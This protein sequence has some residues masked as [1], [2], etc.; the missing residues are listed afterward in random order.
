MRTT[1][2]IRMT[3][4]LLCG[5]LAAAGCADSTARAFLAPSTVNTVG[6]TVRVKGTLSSGAQAALRGGGGKFA[7]GQPAALALGAVG[8]RAYGT[9]GRVVNGAFTAA[10]ASFTIDLPSSLRRRYAICFSDDGFASRVFTVAFAGASGAAAGETRVPSTGAASGVIDLGAL[11]AGSVARLN[12]QNGANSDTGN[13]NARVFT[14]AN[15]PLAAVDSDGDG[16]ADLTDTDDDNNGVLDA[17][18][19]NPLDPDGDGAIRLFD[20][21]WDN[22]GQANSVDTDDD[23]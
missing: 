10:D 18:E 16:V 1:T 11:A 22:D 19:V 6:Q 13:P 7:L 21:D 15:N 12:R 3:A 5:A 9:D 23:G 8:V 4:A 14:P 2:T 20:D 17:A